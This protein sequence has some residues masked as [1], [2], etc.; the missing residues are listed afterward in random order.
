MCFF[1]FRLSSLTVPIDFCELS[2]ERQ[3]RPN[4]R[5]KNSTIPQ[6]LFD[7]SRYLFSRSN[8][9]SPPIN[10]ISAFSPAVVLFR[11][12]SQAFF[13]RGRCTRKQQL[14]NFATQSPI[15]PCTKRSLWLEFRKRPVRG[16]I[17][18]VRRSFHVLHHNMRSELRLCSRFSRDNSIKYG[19]GKISLILFA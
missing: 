18:L 10:L 17:S 2:C 11:F 16:N 9:F 8:P 4:V 6:T 1:P 13:F 12:L 19:E 14:S 3:R 5:G 7:P 15:V